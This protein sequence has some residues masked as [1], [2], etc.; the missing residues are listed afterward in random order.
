MDVQHYLAFLDARKKD[1]QRIARHSRGESQPEDVQGKICLIADELSQ[2]CSHP[3]DF[4]NPEDQKI[5]IAHIDRK[6]VR[7][8]EINVRY[9]A[10]LDNTAPERSHPNYAHRLTHGSIEDSL[11]K[12]L[13]QADI[14]LVTGVELSLIGLC[15]GRCV[16]SLQ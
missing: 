16:K 12:L 5:L 2:R 9:A 8:Y 13:I 10:R 4:H 6:L 1:I 14:P 7:Y 11:N 3:I 15:L